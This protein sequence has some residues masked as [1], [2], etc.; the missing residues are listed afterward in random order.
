MYEYSA[1]KLWVRLASALLAADLVPM[2][3]E[4]LTIRSTVPLRHR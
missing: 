1:P 4:V 2:V 3:I